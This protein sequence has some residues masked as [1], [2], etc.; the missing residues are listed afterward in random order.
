[1]NNH[2]HYPDFLKFSICS[3][4]F[5]LTFSSLCPPSAAQLEEEMKILRMFY[6]EKELVVSP[7]RHPKPIS[8]V[9]ENI[10][11]I[12]A[13]EIERMN[14]HSVAEVLN[15]IP[16][17][18]INF[19]QDF[20]ALSL[21]H[22][23]GSEQRHVLVLLDGV[24]WN[25]LASAAAETNSIPVGIIERIEVIKGPASVLYGT[26]ALGGVINIIT[27]KLAESRQVDY[28]FSYGSYDTYQHRL[29]AGGASGPLSFYATADKRQSDGHLPNAAYDGR[30]FTAQAGYEI[31]DQVQARTDQ[32]GPRF[33]AAHR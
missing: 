10:T 6:K 30:D 32:A 5:I 13:K 1:M 33:D 23:Q 29:R 19:N 26:D 16:G 2:Y 15:R 7:T 25:F 27:R 18:F 11:V 17:L 24:P 3:I 8:Q 31:T 28:T 14:A 12:T 9:A 20:G 22:C 21:I 4:L